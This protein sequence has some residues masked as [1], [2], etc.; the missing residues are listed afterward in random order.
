M[1]ANFGKSEDQDAIVRD[2]SLVWIFCKDKTIS[3]ER[4]TIS[5][6]KFLNIYNRPTLF[7]RIEFDDQRGFNLI[8]SFFFSP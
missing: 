1:Y 2:I 8:Y 6:G 5:L 4:N 3:R 7:R